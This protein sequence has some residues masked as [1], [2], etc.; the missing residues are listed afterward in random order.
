MAFIKKNTVLI[1]SVAELKEADYSKNPKLG[2][3]YSVC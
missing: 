3:I 2:D 1:D